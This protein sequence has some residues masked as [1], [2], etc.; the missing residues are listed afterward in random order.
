MDSP[1]L[2]MEAGQF[3]SGTVEPQLCVLHPRKLCV[4]SVSSVIG[5]VQHGHHYTI[6]LMYEHKLEHTAFNMAHGKFGAV[7]DRD[8]ICVQA[9]DG[10]LTFYEQETFSFQSFLPNFLLPGPIQYVGE[11]DC[12]LIG[13]SAR[14]LECYK[15]NTIATSSISGNAKKLAPEWSKS[16]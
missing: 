15:Y 7:K 16:L 1:I 3:V 8:F 14:N 13:T 6:N 5:S 4:Y 2:Q 9:M 11:K 10:V 12:F